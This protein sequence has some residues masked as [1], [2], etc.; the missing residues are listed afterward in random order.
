MYSYIVSLKLSKIWTMVLKEFSGRVAATVPHP[1][2][3]AFSGTPRHVRV[4]QLPPAQTELRH[5][6]FSA[7]C[8]LQ[9]VTTAWRFRGDR[10]T[11]LRVEHFLH[12]AQRGIT[13]LDDVSYIP[14]TIRYIRHI[15]YIIRDWG[16]FQGIL[17]FIWIRDGCRIIAARSCSLVTTKGNFSLDRTVN[18]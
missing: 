15:R 4:S 12:S 16:V 6:G 8:W 11:L 9:R 13:C 3:D 2:T 1:V 5:L 14:V 18:Y 7:W 17:N 10:T